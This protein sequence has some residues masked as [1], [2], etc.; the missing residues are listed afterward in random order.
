VKAAYSHPIQQQ[1]LRLHKIGQELLKYCTAHGTKV[2]QVYKLLETTFKKLDHLFKIV[3]IS[4]LTRGTR[5]VPFTIYLYGKTGQGKSFLST[6]LPAVLAGCKPDEP[7]LTY[8]RN[9][10]MK[11]WDGYTGQYA[12]KYDDF[13]AI[14]QS[15]AQPGEWEKL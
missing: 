9:P 13:A 7:N 11:F 2:G 12:V 1:I 14:D 6:I 15:S 3:D 4:T 8:S 10:N 5:R